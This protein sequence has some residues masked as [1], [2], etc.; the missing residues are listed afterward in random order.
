MK[1]YFLVIFY[2]NNINRIIILIQLKNNIKSNKN[3]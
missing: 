3:Y 2:N 1:K